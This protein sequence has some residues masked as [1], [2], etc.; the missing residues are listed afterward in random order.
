MLLQETYNLSVS[1]LSGFSVFSLNLYEIF[2]WN[3]K[4]ILK[5]SAR[6]QKLDFMWT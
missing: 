1:N 6:N 4:K 2:I 5:I 3:N